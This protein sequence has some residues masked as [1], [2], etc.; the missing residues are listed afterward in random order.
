MA[1]TSIYLQLDYLL[2]TTQGRVDELSEFGYI[3]NDLYELSQMTDILFGSL[4]F[5]K[6]NL[7]KA[8]L[9]EGEKVKKA[10]ELKEKTNTIKSMILNA[11]VLQYLVSAE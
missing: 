3:H 7:Y 1:S 8:A 10:E 5:E 2:P 6:E 9:I 4:C 11:K